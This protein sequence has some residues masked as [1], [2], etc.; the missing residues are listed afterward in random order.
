MI[1]QLVH[2]LQ[3]DWEQYKSTVCSHALFM[4]RLFLFSFKE[5][6]SLRETEHC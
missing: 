1:V 5:T 6:D 3:N 2:S 4:L